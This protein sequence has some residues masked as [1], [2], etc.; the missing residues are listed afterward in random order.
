VSSVA[1]YFVLANLPFFLAGIFCGGL[2]AMGKKANEER[3][4]IV[5]AIFYC[6][7]LAPFFFSDVVK[8][9]S[10]AMIFGLVYMASIIP[11][12]FILPQGVA[13][14]AGLTLATFAALI[15]KSN[16]S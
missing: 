5:L 4:L 2:M 8:N 11:L 16:Q 7:A 3:L 14:F 1:S 15:F 9:E 13:F 10:L 6:I 12:I